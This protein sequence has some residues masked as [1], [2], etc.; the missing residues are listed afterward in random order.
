M[1]KN[2]SEISMIQPNVMVLFVVPAFW[3]ARVRGLQAKA[4]SDRVTKSEK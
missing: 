1:F 3:K 2:L 4:Q